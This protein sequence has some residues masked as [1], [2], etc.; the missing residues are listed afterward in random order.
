VAIVALRG[1]NYGS[2]YVISCKL[3]PH[4][5]NKFECDIIY[6]TLIKRNKMNFINLFVNYRKFFVILFF[7]INMIPLCS[8]DTESYNKIAEEIREYKIKNGDAPTEEDLYQ[9]IQKPQCSLSSEELGQLRQLV[10]QQ[11]IPYITK[12]K[13]SKIIIAKMESIHDFTCQYTLNQKIFH[14]N[15]CVDSV[16]FFEYS[17]KGNKRLIDFK[18]EGKSSNGHSIPSLRR[19]YDGNQVIDLIT[20]ENSLQ[21]AIVMDDTMSFVDENI[22]LASVMLL[23][24]SSFVDEKKFVAHYLENFNLALFLKI[25]DVYVH[26][27]E[28]LIKENKM[29]C[30]RK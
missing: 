14:E 6:A 7:F 26:E 2:M 4:N 27:K 22:P 9:I 13:L 8:G 19:S 21:T 30:R 16:F 18:S 12:E 1:F 17:Q 29:Y 28:T 25:S 3:T 10:G 24:V 20:P 11:H 15:K 5:F 23:D